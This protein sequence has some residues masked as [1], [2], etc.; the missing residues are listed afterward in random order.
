M[1]SNRGLY[2]YYRP[3][4]AKQNDNKIGQYQ[5]IERG[6]LQGCVV[7]PNL[8]SLYSENVVRNVEEMRGSTVRGRNT[9]CIRYAD[10]KLQIAENEH[11]MH[12]L[13][14]AIIFSEIMVV[15]KK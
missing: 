7:S 9:N 8:F 11:G 15:S 14:D 1:G 6:V 4:A 12:N 13:V 5:P 3:H 10:D 2:I